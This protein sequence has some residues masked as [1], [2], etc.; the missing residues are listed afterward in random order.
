ASAHGS[1]TAGPMWYDAMNAIQKYLP[2][3]D[4]VKPVKVYT[5]PTNGNVPSVVGM[6]VKDATTTLE[7]LGFRVNIGG[8]VY[9]DSV[10]KGLVARTSPASGSQVPDGSAIT[11]YISA[12]PQ[13][14]GTG[15]GGGGGGGPGG[16]GGGGGPG[17]LPSPTATP[18]KGHGHH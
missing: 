14:T 10:T 16:G 4:F 18:T 12:G 1:T 13:K 6:T 17:G 5:V 7:S 15:G 3:E 11:L 8:A 2:D 9:S